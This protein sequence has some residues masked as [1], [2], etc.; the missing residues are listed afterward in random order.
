MQS[1]LLSR[2]RTEGIITILIII[3]TEL[4]PRGAPKRCLEDSTCCHPRCFVR[5]LTIGTIGN[6]QLKL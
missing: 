6:R 2:R 3:L 1:N 5:T 4:R